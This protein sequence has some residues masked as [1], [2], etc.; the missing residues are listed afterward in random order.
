M[1]RVLPRLKQVPVS[2]EKF[3]LPRKCP[4]SLRRPVPPRPSFAAV[5]HVRSILLDDATTNPITNPRV[6]IRHKS[7]PPLPRRFDKTRE[8]TEDD[9]PRAMSFDERRFASSPYLRMLAS[10]LRQCILTS[11]FMPNDFLVRLA[12]QRVPGAQHTFIP[13]GLQHTK[14]TAR[15]S[16]HAH[17]VPCTRHAIALL[18][19]LSIRRR[20]AHGIR[21]H[22]LLADHI[23]HLLRLRVLQELEVL[24][25]TLQ[26]S[27]RASNAP[28]LRRLT[29]AELATIRNTHTV[30]HPGALAVLIVPPLQKDPATGLRPAPNM[31]P[32]PPPPDTAPPKR[33][34]DLPACELYP[35]HPPQWPDA[36]G[37]G[38]LPEERIPLYN[39][40]VMFPE[41]GQRAAL[42][43]RLRRLLQ[44]QWEAR[45]PPA[46]EPANSKMSHAFLLCS[47]AESVLR[48]DTVGVAIALWRLRMF[49]DK[50][51]DLQTH[52]VD[53]WEWTT[54]RKVE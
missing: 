17:Y 43:A 22:P 39:G 53:P 4:R 7:L 25:D 14:F 20:A 36:A 5:D 40:A 18:A 24:A 30:P 52:S 12:V 37:D 11:R 29:R 33:P 46:A 41:R 10:P 28:L 44:L 19:N 42:E 48:G 26:S 51:E 3:V 13:D 23:A 45:P 34:L 6:Y 2:F 27:T 15:R 21:P 31:S 47:D 38:I 16:G 54:R 1:V 50:G 9:R 8:P 49:E 32:A 35:V